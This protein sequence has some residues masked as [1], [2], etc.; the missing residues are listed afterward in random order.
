MIYEASFQ[1]AALDKARIE[2]WFT[3]MGYIAI[4][5][6]T[7]DRIAQRL[8]LRAIRHG[9]AVGHEPGTVS[10]DGLQMVFDAVTKGEIFIVVGIALELVSSARVYMVASTKDAIAKSGYKCSDWI[11]PI[12]NDDVEKLSSLGSVV[13]YRAW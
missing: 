11:S 3:N 9:F 10:R 2:F 5:I 13:S 7:Y 4:G 1:P 12:P 6:E 8:R